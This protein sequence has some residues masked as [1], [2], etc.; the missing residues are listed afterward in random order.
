MPHSGL[1]GEYLISIIRFRL[2]NYRSIKGDGYCDINLF[3]YYYISNVTLKHL[4][5][6]SIVINSAFQK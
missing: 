5:P 2:H 3:S 6:N 4:T 1:W